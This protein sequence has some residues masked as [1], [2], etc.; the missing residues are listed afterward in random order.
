MDCPSSVRLRLVHTTVRAVPV[1]GSDGFVG[2]PFRFQFPWPSK[3][4]L[5]RFPWFF[6]FVVSFFCWCVSP[7]FSRD[8]KGSAER[9][10]LAFCGASLPFCQKQQGLAVPVSASEKRIRWFR[11]CFWFLEKQFR[12]FRFPVAV[13]FLSHPGIN[14]ISIEFTLQLH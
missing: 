6:R 8:F 10:I 5:F 12:R 2:G 4:C 13:R 7:F 3:P 11:F 1:L 9:E 14:L